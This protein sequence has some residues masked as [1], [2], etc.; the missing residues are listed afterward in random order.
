MPKKYRI[1]TNKTS[2]KRIFK[3]ALTTAVVGLAI[4]QVA[5]DFSNGY[6]SVT[7]NARNAH[8]HGMTNLLDRV[9][10]NL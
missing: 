6:E 7:R 8:R 4:F 3:T 2:R 5:R 1:T 10:R 9:A